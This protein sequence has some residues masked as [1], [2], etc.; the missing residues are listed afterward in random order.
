MRR[1]EERNVLIHRQLREGR[2]VAY[3]SSGCISLYPRVH[4]GELCCYQPAAFDDQIEEDPI[5]FCNVQPSVYFYA[6][7]V[8]NKEWHYTERRWKASCFGP[9]LMS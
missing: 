1:R 9:S 4:S 3:R 6:H 5:V 2:T 8:K 7:L